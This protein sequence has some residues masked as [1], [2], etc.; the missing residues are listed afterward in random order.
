[1]S[2]LATAGALVPVVKSAID[3]VRKNVTDKDK[4]IELETKLLEINA[5]IIKSNKQLLEKVV[6]LTFPILV[7]FLVIIPTI[8]IMGSVIRFWKTGTYY[9]IIPIKEWMEH[10]FYITMVFVSGLVGKWNIDKF[11]QGKNQNK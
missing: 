10:L 8:V 2:I 4:Q 6:P 3:T 11:W 1:M 9:E 7:W 5:E